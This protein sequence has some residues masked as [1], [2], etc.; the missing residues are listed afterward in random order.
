MRRLTART[1][2][3]G[4][5]GLGLASAGASVLG[6]VPAHAA[7]SVTVANSSGKAVVD[8]EYA[9]KLTVQGR[10]FQSVKGGHGGI[11]VAFGTVDGT[12]RPSQGGIT[13]KDYFYVPDSESGNNGGFQKYVAFP[14]SD[15]SSEANGGVIAA[16]GTWSTTLTVPGSSFQAAD[17]SGKVVTIDCLKVRCGVITLGAHGLKNANNETF[18]PVTFVKGTATA[19][20]GNDKAP[21]GT[22]TTSPDNLTS[23]TDSAAAP[24]V[25]GKPRISID[26][27][28]ARAGAALSFTAGGM[29][30][31]RQVT[32]VFDD[33]AAAAG[34]FLVSADGTFAGVIQL[35]TSTGAGTHELRVYGLKKAP[36]LKFAV[37]AAESPV[38]VS[39]PAAEAGNG[40]LDSTEGRVAV[41]FVALAGV[42]LLGA[43]ARLVLATRR[44]RG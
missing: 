21:T 14:G 33:G 22:A 37:T 2:L 38:P 43:L 27:K 40:V 12:W 42:A 41:G 11:Y 44:R 17:R 34:P 8:P 18:T 32:V 16:N 39:S 26:D 25:L 20:Q 7:G 31:G 10:G 29:T 1:T 24:V 15:T 19:G 5:L 28:S 13:G 30:P 23:P 36:S 9:T 3:A 35:P 6:A 4:V